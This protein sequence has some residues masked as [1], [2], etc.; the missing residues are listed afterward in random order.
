MP[1]P[2]RRY[3]FVIDESYTPDTLPMHRLAEYM[4]DLAA[5]LGEKEHVHFVQVEDGSAV[6]VQDVEHEAYPKVRERVHRV[7]R[8]DAPADASRAFN[9]INR[10]LADD[11]ATGE[12]VEEPA[13]A[14][15]PGEHREAAR[16]L[17]FPGR[18]AFV[19]LPYGPFNQPGTLQGLVIM[20]GG[21]S[22]PVPVHLEDGDAIHICRAKRATARELAR[23]L[24]DTPVRVSGTGRWY[25]DADGHWEMKSF[26][27]SSFVE[28][29][30]DSLVEATAKLRGV[31]RR[32]GKDNLRLLEQVRK[33]EAS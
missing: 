31:R 5:L 1:G 23:C 14:E 30:G 13:P 2:R 21:E 16:V 6:L 22:D 12:L 26:T 18:K 29:S 24:F 3:R 9:S 8:G 19:E 15:V 17:T 11:N 27:I 33:D 28:L 25:R 20:I 7:K 4:A 10:R 32:S